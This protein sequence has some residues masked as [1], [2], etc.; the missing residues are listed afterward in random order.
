MF[1]EDNQAMDGKFT[2]NRLG[3]QMLY[4]RFLQTEIIEKSGKKR[5]QILLIE[6]GLE[7]SKACNVLF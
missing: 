6:M 1:F 3:S 7:L 4:E 5:S 2:K